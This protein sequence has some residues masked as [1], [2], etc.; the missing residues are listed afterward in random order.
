MIIL[1]VFTCSDVTDH[2]V[3]TIAFRSMFSLVYKCIDILFIPYYYLISIT[4]FIKNLG[5]GV[6]TPIVNKS[7]FEDIDIT[8]PKLPT[9]RKIAS[10]LSAYD[11]LIENNLKRIKLLEE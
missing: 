6:A 11:D 9:Q 5:G 7:K 2:D 8:I 3:M 1:I 10:I 4:P